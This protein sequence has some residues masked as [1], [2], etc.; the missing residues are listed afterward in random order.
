MLPTTHDI[1]SGALSSTPRFFLAFIRRTPILGTKIWEGKMKSLL[2]VTFMVLFAYSAFAQN[3]QDNPNAEL[4][5]WRK[6]VA[7]QTRQYE[8][9]KQQ[10]SADRE[11]WLAK[12]KD[13]EKPASRREKVMKVLGYVG[14]KLISGTIN[15]Y[16]N[17]AAIRSEMGRFDSRFG[18]IRTDIASAQ[19]ASA[20]GNADL[21]RQIAAGNAALSSQL[22]ADNTAL[23]RQLGETAAAQATSNASLARRIDD[24]NAAIIDANAAIIGGTRSILN[25]MLPPC[26][27]PT[28]FGEVLK[29]PQPCRG[30]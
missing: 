6:L 23:S 14:D 17:R 13:T 21:G 5:A 27:I 1:S 22:T 25:Q 24:A 8:E 3:V 28:P 7:D 12:M 19:Q 2:F 20:A 9:T 4:D 11:L 26:V 18:T 30:F 29:S 16:A 10:Y 15:Y